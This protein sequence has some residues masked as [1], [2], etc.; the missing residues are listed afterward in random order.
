MFN[1]TQTSHSVSVIV[2]PN[3]TII[4]HSTDQHKT[5]NIN[6]TYFLFVLQNIRGN[7][8]VSYQDG[9]IAS[10]PQKENM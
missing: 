2:K 3:P 10:I 4:T 5:F 1:W 9:H 8:V 6:F 7:K